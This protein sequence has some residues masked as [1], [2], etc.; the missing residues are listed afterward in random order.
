MTGIF[1]SM[2][3]YGNNIRNFKFTLLTSYGKWR[4]LIWYY[5]LMSNILPCNCGWYISTNFGKIIPNYMAS[6]PKTC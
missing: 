2:T 5:F 3:Y 1:R 4:H 6:F